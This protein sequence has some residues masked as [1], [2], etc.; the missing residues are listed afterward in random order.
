MKP[1][2]PWLSQSQLSGLDPDTHEG[3]YLAWLLPTAI[4]VIVLVVLG[5]CKHFGWLQ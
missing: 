1:P 4:T 3:E 5:A 2:E